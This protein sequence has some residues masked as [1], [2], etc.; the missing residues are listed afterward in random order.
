MPQKNEQNTNETE[1]ETSP[2]ATKVQYLIAAEDGKVY[3]NK[4][5]LPLESLKKMQ[6][7]QSI[8]ALL[9]F[10]FDP[11]NKTF[12]IQDPGWLKLYQ[13]GDRGVAALV[14]RAAQYLQEMYGVRTLNQQW[15]EP[16]NSAIL[17]KLSDYGVA[18][19]QVMNFMQKEFKTDPVDVPVIEYIP[20]KNN[21][22]ND[23]ITFSP[24]GADIGGV[25]T[26]EPCLVLNRNAYMSEGQP[27]YGVINQ[28]LTNAYFQLLEQIT[29]TAASPEQKARIRSEWT[30]DLLHKKGGYDVYFAVWTD[31]GTQILKTNDAQRNRVVNEAT[32]R[33]E[34]GMK[35]YPKGYPLII[36]SSV[37]GT[38]QLIFQ[39]HHPQDL[40]QYPVYKQM[41]DDIKRIMSKDKSVAEDK[42]VLGYDSSSASPFITK[43][44]NYK[45]LWDY[46]TNFLAPRYKFEPQDIP[47]VEAPLSKDGMMKAVF[48]TSPTD[49]K[50]KAPLELEHRVSNGIVVPYPFIAVE[51]R[52]P[53][54]GM[55]YH[56]LLHEYQHFV[57]Q[58]QGIPF[59]GYSFQGGMNVG[60]LQERQ[61]RFIEYINNPLEQ[62]AHLKQMIYMLEMGMT[63]GHIMDFFG[64]NDSIL[65]KA[66]YGRL[67]EKAEKIYDDERQKAR[68][69]V[70]PPNPTQRTAG[71][72]GTSE[73]TL[74]L[75]INDWW[76]F[77][78]LE[79]LV[80]GVH[81]NDKQNPDVV[82]KVQKP[83]NLK[84]KKKAPEG[85][86]ATE[87]LLT[88]QHDDDLKYMK[89]VEQ[90]LRENRI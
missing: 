78:N 46:I 51:N 31:K 16:P 1:T 17:R 74:D 76:Y 29:D 26:K 86:R 14:N 57:Q 79:A 27:D 52:L 34:P 64:A 32:L 68:S 61:K 41:L 90:L 39:N 10:A 65:A 63:P 25:S 84:D 81:Q 4:L 13:E 33:A 48:L 80:S 70:H 60:D 66:N 72:S 43:M 85:P 9:R 44:S 3:L 37:P 36:F 82:P 23:D 35:G 53:N 42:L 28:D 20:E 87:G 38:P 88:P 12:Y 73:S 59:I 45:V 56:A 58:I 2:E 19:R 30:N 6:R 71:T 69:V 15:G 89:S 55:K 8:G 5:N 83:Y 18:W 67:L 7:F 40:L 47:V 49:E 24:D 11:R 62:D 21:Q 77:G 50:T 75:G 22:E 54:L